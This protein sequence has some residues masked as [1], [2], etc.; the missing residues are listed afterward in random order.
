MVVV[1]VMAVATVGAMVV[2]MAA[3]AVAAIAVA[4][5]ADPAFFTSTRAC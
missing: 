5:V 2:E 4:L 3:A 1:V